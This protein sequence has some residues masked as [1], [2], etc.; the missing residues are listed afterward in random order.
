MTKKEAITKI[1]SFYKGDNPI[2]ITSCGKTSRE[3]WAI[4]RQLEMDIIPLT[5]SMGMATS[6]SIGMAMA[7]PF[8]EVIVIMGD[9]EYM[10]GFNAVLHLESAYVNRIK[11]FI[12]VDHEYESTGRQINIWFNDISVMTWEVYDYV[13]TRLRLEEKD[14][15]GKV[16]CLVPVEASKKKAPRIPD[17]ELPK[18]I[19]RN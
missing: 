5:G 7:D 2:V 17:S 14:K 13:Y 19:R 12:L 9:G 3:A 1:L 6:L 8:R 11:H 10:M 4:A 15:Q 16:L 18:T